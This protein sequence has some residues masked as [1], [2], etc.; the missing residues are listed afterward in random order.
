[1]E[2]AL[3][4][5]MKKLIILTAVFGI[6][7]L[8]QATTIN[9]PSSLV[10]YDALSGEN[11]YSW[12]IS[13]SLAAGQ[14]ITSAQID[15]TGITLSASGN[16]A[17]TGELYTDLLNSQHSGV[18]TATDNDS[19]GDY[20]ATQF[21]G[22]NISSVG[23]QL[24]PYVGFTTNLDYTLD[25]AELSALNSYLASGGFSIGID[26]DCH[27]SPSGICFTYTTTPV[28]N[29]VPDGTFTAALLLLGLGS[30]ELFRRRLNLARVK[31]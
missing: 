19:P 25:A 30:V 31:A 15:F 9:A 21:S 1:M 22:K 18:V 4:V 23:S 28:S 12:G 20:W 2:D 7:T 26:P 24:F 5:G 3:E 11:A 6:S 13:I 10:G 16:N 17:G 29:T 8:V 14:T 27:Y